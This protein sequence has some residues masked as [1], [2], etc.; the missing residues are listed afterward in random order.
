MAKMIFVNLPVADVA[1]STAFYEAIGMKRNPTFSNDRASAMEWSD[2]IGFMLL[3][4]A[5]YSTF[6]DKKIIDARKSSG[7]LIAL[8]FDSR[9]AVDAITEAALAAGG[10]E[11]HDPENEPYM[12]SRAFEDLDGHGFGPFWMDMAA[13]EQ[14]LAPV[15]G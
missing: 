14:A 10:R 5:F 15:N 11:L 3:D 13:A 1:K 2:T 8:S 6:T 9:D 4:H 7:A 12:Y